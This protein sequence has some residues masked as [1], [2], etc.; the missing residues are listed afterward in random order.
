MD[1]VTQNF[2]KILVVDK[3]SENRQRYV[4][5]RAALVE[6]YKVAVDVYKIE[7]DLYTKKEIAGE[8]TKDDKHPSKPQLMA[9]QTE[10]YDMY[11]DMLQSSEDDSIEMDIE[12]FNKLW[13]DDWHWMKQHT[14][15][16]R[17]FMDQF[18]SKSLN[19]TWDSSTLSAMNVSSK[20]L[21]MALLAYG[22]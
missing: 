16:M 4:D 17:A 3:I 8:L 14:G 7:Y 20:K 21:N 6:A 13:R 22:G 9:E 12:E 18:D 19:G 2:E 11:I 10:N 1:Q 15:Y 5:S